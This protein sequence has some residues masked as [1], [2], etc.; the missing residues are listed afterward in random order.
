MKI[1]AIETST[2]TGGAAIVEDHKLL[3]EGR[4]SL[5]AIHSERLMGL[6]DFLLKAIKMTIYDMDYLAVGVGPGSFTGLRVGIATVKGLAYGTGK[7]VAPVS[8]LEAFAANIPFAQDCLICPMLDA[9]RHEIYVALYRQG[10]SGLETVLTERAARLADIVAYI[11][12]KTL[13]IGDGAVVYRSKIE[14]ALGERATFLTGTAMYPSAANVAFLAMR[15]IQT[16]N[17]VNALE[18]SPQYLRPSEAEIK[19]GSP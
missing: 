18:L 2:I 9:K 19:F 6:I 11:D 8:S 17:I 7:L 1:L 12:R 15:N 14:E 13:F 3:A 10:D 16:G 5:K 4:L